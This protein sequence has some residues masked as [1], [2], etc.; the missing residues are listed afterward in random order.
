MSKIAELLKLA[1][2]KKGNKSQTE[3][4]LPKL[5]NE[6]ETIKNN[7]D[8]VSVSKSKIEGASVSKSNYKELRVS[9]SNEEGVSVSKS[10][11]EQLG[12][13]TA[14]PI[15]NR[16]NRVKTNTVEV[17]PARDFTKVS[18][19]ITKR[20]IP[21]KYF[22][23]LSKHTYDVLYQRT[24]GAI[25][26]TRTIQ[27]TKD[28]LVRLT[29]LSKDAIKLHIKYLKEIGLLSSRPAIGSHAGWEYEIFVPEEIED[30]EQVGVRQDN[31]MQGKAGEN[32]PLHTEQNLRLLTHSNLIENKGT[33]EFPKTSLKTNTKNDDDTR[34]SETFSAMGKRL[35]EAARKLTGKGV[36]PS[37]M[38]KWET[39]AELLILELETAAI[40]TDSISSVPAFLTEVLRRKLLGGNSP[41]AVKSSKTKPDTVGKPNEAGEYEKKPLDAAGREVALS[42]LRDFADE[43][44]LTD[45]EKWYTAEDW[46]WLTTELD[47]IRQS[48]KTA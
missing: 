36:S 19:S 20:A 14:N 40:R 47:K 28:E 38:Q 9:K 32:L 30:T 3:L 13:S 42:E 2:Q 29:G 10:N 23:G 25:N 31:A 39:L 17:S 11:K 34:V 18:N 33:Y 5:I 16:T 6:S 1:E 12:I 26:P 46:S 22:R 35:D 8:G 44:F 21:E 24:R 7:P 45:F 37:E 15:S 27:L 4:V 48:S 43:D 41:A